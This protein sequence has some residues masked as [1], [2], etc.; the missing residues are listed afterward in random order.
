MCKWILIIISL[1]LGCH[2]LVAQDVVGCTQLLED[3]KEAYAAGM[4]ELV[5]ELLLPCIE[6]GGMTGTTKQ[7]AY[8]LLINAYLFDYLPEEADSL[9]DDFVEEFPDYRASA[10][11]ASEF[12]LLLETHLR[13]RGIDPNAVV[14]S[15]DQRNQVTEPVRTSDTRARYRTPFVYGN[16][17]GFIVGSNGTFPQIIERYSFGD[18]AAD[19][20]SFGFAPGF[21][22]GATMNLLLNDRLE[23]SFGVLY[24]RTRFSFTSSPFLFSS[25]TYE[26]S[27]DHLQI[28]AAM[29]L[30]LNPETSGTSV[31]LRVGVVADY[32]LGAS[33]AGTRSY[34]ESLRDI[35]VEKTKIKDSRARMNLHGMAGLGVRIPFERAFLF[36][37]TRI[38]SGLFLVNREEN[39]YENQ[40]LTWLL[41]H[42]DSDF[43]IHQVSFSAGIAWNL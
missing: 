1:C 22:L 20:G 33:G 38:T 35:V 32:L 30:K 25:Y 3:A 24:N 13:A 41:Y 11:D 23:T 34:T 40:D 29:I 39:R 5:P 37:E 6:S 19:K 15:D 17:M 27:Q 18:P 16:S 9:M 14:I 26:E 10:S 8:K 31:Y 28:P 4:V 12:V 2:S 36:L 42:V 43:R 7:E 21:Q